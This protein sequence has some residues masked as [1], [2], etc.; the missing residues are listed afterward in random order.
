MSLIEISKRCHWCSKQRPASRVHVLK[1]GQSICDYCIEWHFHAMDVLGGA[2]PSGCQECGASWS[3][4]QARSL[5][6]T[7]MI[8]VPKDGMYQML[9]EEC[10]LPYTR[11]RLDLYGGTRYGSELAV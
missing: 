9:C 8:C 1:S 6:A 2:V 5:L 4:L 3:D 7:K 11:K 10:A